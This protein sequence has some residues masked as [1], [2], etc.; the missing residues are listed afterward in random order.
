MSRRAEDIAKRIK[1]FS[2][3]VVAFVENL[4]EEDWNKICDPEQWSVGVTARHI[5]AGHFAISDMTAK[6]VRGEGLPPLTMDQINAM[7]NKDS[8]EHADCTQSEALELLRK[9]G[10]E[11]AA[12]V[13]DLS[14]AD[15]DRNCSMPAF[16]G[17]VSAERFIDLIIFRSA[18]QHFDSMK[19][20]VG[21]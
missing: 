2:D 4:S 19:A 5:G 10:A 12:F 13:A 21:G 8:H 11:M 14:D 17:E 16:G 6:I 18:A 15:L 3:E 1:S 9:N 7:S 20:A